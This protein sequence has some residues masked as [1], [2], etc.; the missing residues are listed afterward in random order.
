MPPLT[1][2]SLATTTTSW[3]VHAADAGDDAGAGRGPV[4]HAVGGQR[5]EFEEG[6]AGVE[7]GGDAF[8]REQLAALGVLGPG[9]LAA[10]Q[11]DALELG[12]E[13]GHLLPEVLGVFTELR[14]T[15]IDQ[16]LEQGHGVGSLANR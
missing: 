1:V 9:L 16:G 8:A 11:G 3:P 5:G 13:I 7:Q 6:R 2:A 12:I 4:V 14:A 10:A 15:G